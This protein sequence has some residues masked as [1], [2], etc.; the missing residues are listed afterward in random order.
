LW[1]LKVL[2]SGDVDMTRV[3]CGRHSWRGKRP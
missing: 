3:L 1:L 2:R